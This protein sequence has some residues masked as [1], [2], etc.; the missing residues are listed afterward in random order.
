MVRALEERRRRKPPYRL[1]WNTEQIFRSR[2]TAA[3]S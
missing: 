1:R 2:S 3:H